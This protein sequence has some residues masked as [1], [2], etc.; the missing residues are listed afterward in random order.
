MIIRIHDTE[1]DRAWLIPDSTVPN[2]DGGIVLDLQRRPAGSIELIDPRTCEAVAHADL[3]ATDPSVLV[4]Y[5]QTY[6]ADN[7]GDLEW[8]VQAAVDT[9]LAEPTPPI[10]GTTQCLTDA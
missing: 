1:G 6:G 7:A 9:M 10:P 2:S 3:P 8:K 4:T 5:W